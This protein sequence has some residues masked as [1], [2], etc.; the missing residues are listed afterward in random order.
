V[1]S[2]IEAASGRYVIDDAVSSAAAYLIGAG[3]TRCPVYR[4]LFRDSQ[5]AR[6]GLQTVTLEH[7]IPYDW[8]IR[9]VTCGSSRRAAGLLLVRA[10]GGWLA[11][12]GHRGHGGPTEAQRLF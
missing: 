7:E 9:T 2:K 10:Q 3:G 11:E 8:R 6:D 1:R 5:S 12:R 4:T